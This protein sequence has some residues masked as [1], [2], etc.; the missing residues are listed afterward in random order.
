MTKIITK[1]CSIVI[2]FG[3]FMLPLYSS[4]GIA[5]TICADTIQPIWCNLWNES[6]GGDARTLA[7]DNTGIYMGGRILELST[8][9][10]AVQKC[11]FNGDMLG[12]ISWNDALSVHS[13]AA[14]NSGLYIIAENYTFNASTKELVLKYDTNGKLSWN[15]PPRSKLRGI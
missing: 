4:E 8:N 7:I 11:G 14:D 9:Y 15:E 13:M 5:N 1:L 10:V 12:N 3:L 2:A 6:K